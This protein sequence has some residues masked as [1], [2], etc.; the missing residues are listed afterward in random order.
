[1]PSQYTQ[2]IQDTQVPNVP[3]AC[4]SSQMKAFLTAHGCQIDPA[5][6]D[7]NCPFRAL[8][9]QMTG[10][11]S[12]HPELRKVLTTFISQN[13]Q[14]FGRGWTIGNRSLE[15]H[16]DQVS[17]LGHYGTH[18]EIKATASL[19]QKPIYVATDSLS[20]SKCMWTVFPPFHPT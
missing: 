18:A 10:D 12:R 11:P 7:G 5:L 13:P 1:M 6:P 15:E 20:V 4:S 8:T 16:L 3:P 17:K 2:N 19:C 14:V 9:K